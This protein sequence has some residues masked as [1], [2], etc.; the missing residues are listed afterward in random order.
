MAPIKRLMIVWLTMLIVFANS[1]AILKDFDRTVAGRF[2]SHNTP[3]KLP[4]SGYL[5]S[6]HG[7]KANSHFLKR[8]N[9]GDTVAIFENEH[10]TDPKYA[11]L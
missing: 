2:M 10:L 6:R 7:K 9:G 4:T 11:E 3:Q 1:R 8:Q 5:T